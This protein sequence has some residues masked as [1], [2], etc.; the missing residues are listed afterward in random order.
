MTKI[1]QRY[2]NNSVGYEKKRG[3]KN[4]MKI[5][6]LYLYVVCVLKERK[7][8]KKKHTK[9]E[10]NKKTRRKKIIRRRR[11]KCERCAIASPVV[12]TIK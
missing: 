2:S 8:N 11:S 6:Y 7:I 10:T 9:Q 3:A 4:T 1:H 5:V 12:I